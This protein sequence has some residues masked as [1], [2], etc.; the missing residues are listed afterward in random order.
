MSSG[1]TSR[2]IGNCCGVDAKHIWGMSYYRWMSSCLVIAFGCAPAT[3]MSKEEVPTS[4]DLTLSGQIHTDDEGRLSRFY[5]ELD[6]GQDSAAENSVRFA[7]EF[8]DELGVEDGSLRVGRQRAS[9]SG[10]VTEL[11]QEFN[12]LPVFTGNAM[13]ETDD[14]DIITTVTNTMVNEDQL[15]ELPSTPDIKPDGVRQALEEAR[16]SKIESIQ[17]ATLGYFSKL[18]EDGRT[19]VNELAYEVIVDGTSK[20]FMSH[21]GKIIGEKKLVY[22][23]E[24]AK[25]ISVVDWNHDSKG[26]HRII[27]GGQMVSDGSSRDAALK[28]DAF[29][30]TLDDSMRDIFAISAGTSDSRDVNIWTNYPGIPGFPGIRNAVANAAPCSNAGR[31]AYYSDT[32]RTVMFCPQN[33]AMPNAMVV[34]HEA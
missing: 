2:S 13:I 10:A 5:G 26:A 11:R 34:Y 17:S 29:R 1:Q 33:T 30:Q 25:T 19:Q 6:L 18:L 7:E 12:G 20:Y 15:N 22:A 8:A 24:S 28:A 21:D 27:D 3:G 14:E 23:S 4:T 32:N 31:G 16:G 9:D